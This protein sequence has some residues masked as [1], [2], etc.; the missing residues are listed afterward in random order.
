[1]PKVCTDGYV[2]VWVELG[3]ETKGREAGERG[4]YDVGAIG[5]E[6]DVGCG[7]QVFEHVKEDMSNRRVALFG[8]V[9]CPVRFTREGFV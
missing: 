6:W 2:A 5:R 3:N 8:T 4:E 9:N 1:M 7:F